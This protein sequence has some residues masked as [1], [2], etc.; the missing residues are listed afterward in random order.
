MPEPEAPDPLDPS[1]SV[2]MRKLAKSGLLEKIVTWAVIALVGGG[3]S[4][5]TQKVSDANGAAAIEA[6]KLDLTQTK[7]DFERFKTNYYKRLRS[8]QADHLC[9]ERRFVRLEVRAGIEAPGCAV[10][11]SEE[12]AS[13]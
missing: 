6:V 2:I 13:R 10:A 12:L 5:A 3:A 7:A 1:T 8:G 11:S 9:F 4:M